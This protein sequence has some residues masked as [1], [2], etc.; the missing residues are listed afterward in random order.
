MWQDLWAHFRRCSTRAPKLI[1]E[2]STA[3]ERV[4]QFGSAASLG[5]HNAS[6]GPFLTCLTKAS[7]SARALCMGH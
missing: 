5:A 3:E 4:N 7:F 6:L 1:D 2:L